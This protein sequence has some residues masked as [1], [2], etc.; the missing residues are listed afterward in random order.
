[1]SEN[2]KER[3]IAAGDDRKELGVA[4]ASSLGGLSGGARTGLT[5]CIVRLTIDCRMLTR[6]LP[7]SHADQNLV[8][9]RQPSNWL[10]S[11]EETDPI[12]TN[13]WPQFVG[14]VI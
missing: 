10:Q 11:T 9:V 8:I 3:W 12:P 4:P 5:I 1:M 6:L 2:K 13:I 7:A 14:L